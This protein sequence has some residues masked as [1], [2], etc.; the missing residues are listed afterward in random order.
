MIIYS[1]IYIPLPARHFHP[2]CPLQEQEE[3]MADVPQHTTCLPSQQ[4]E[5]MEKWQ[6]PTIQNICPRSMNFLVKLISFYYASPYL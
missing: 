6:S 4:Y 3:P 5:R 1:G 2:C